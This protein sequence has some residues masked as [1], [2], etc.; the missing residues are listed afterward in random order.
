VLHKGA[1]RTE[2]DLAKKRPGKDLDFLRMEFA[3]EYKYLQPVWERLYGKQVR[4]LSNVFLMVSDVDTAFS[5]WMEEWGK[6][7]LVHRCDGEWQEAWFDVS[8][9][10]VNRSDPK[11]CESTRCECKQIGRINLILP[12]L[13]IE[14]GALGYITLQTHSIRDIKRLYS[15]L[16]YLQSLHGTLMGVPF[17]ISRR[18]E[19]IEVPKVDRNKQPTGERMKVSKSLLNIKADDF[20][21]QQQLAPRLMAAANALPANVDPVT[22]EVL[23]RPALPAPQKQHPVKWSKE[24]ARAWFGIMQEKHALTA[25]DLRTALGVSSWEEWHSDADAAT[26]A[27]NEWLDLQLNLFETEDTKVTTEEPEIEY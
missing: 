5:V 23:S 7:G 9:G 18:M 19:T 17:V 20:F 27:V 6:S 24:G 16:A 11:A 14:T 12:E 26:E 22:G 3:E 10:K 8:Q 4:V 15:L 13:L 2:E 1:A 21:T 25:N